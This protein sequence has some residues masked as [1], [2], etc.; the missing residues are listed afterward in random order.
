[1]SSAISA[2]FSDIGSLFASD[3]GVAV[4]LDAIVENYVGSDGFIDTRTDGLDGSLEI[5]KDQLLRLDIRSANLESRLLKQFTALD[6]LIAQLTSTG[7]F[8][9]Q[10]LASLPAPLSINK[11]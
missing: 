6:S 2:N 8:L 1:L 5:I 3:D 7:N 9:A 11:N 4:K 10:Q